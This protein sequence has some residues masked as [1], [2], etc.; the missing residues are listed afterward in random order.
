MTRP[1]TVS[2]AAT[3]P[4]TST[5]AAV[6]SGSPA[7]TPRMELGALHRRPAPSDPRVPGSNGSP[8]SDIFDRDDRKV[9]AP[10]GSAS[11]S[12]RASVTGTD[13]GDDGY[14]SDTT[15]STIPPSYRTRRTT[16]FRAEKHP[17]PSSTPST[18]TEP[19]DAHPPSSFTRKRSRRRMHGSRVVQHQNAPGHAQ[20][21]VGSRG[22]PFRRKQSKDGGVRLA[23]GSSGPFEQEILP[24]EYEE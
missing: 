16:I 2:I 24:P 11:V 17:L 4:S 19:P 5:A 8:S 13:A 23:G 22:Q 12:T 20:V 10:S 7:I 18:S 6:Q 14:L 1:S 21:S 3:R 9:I 15:M